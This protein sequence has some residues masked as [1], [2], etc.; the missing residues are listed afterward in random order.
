MKLGVFTPVVA[1]IPLEEALKYLHTK[2]VQMVEIG[3][4]GY[5]GNAHCDPDQLLGHPEKLQQF[6]DLLKKYDLELS[7]LSCHSNPVHPPK[8]GRP[9][10]GSADSQNDLVGRE[11][12]PPQHQHFLWLSW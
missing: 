7:A 5:P 8:E 10:G 12:G 1:N 11:T 3:T 4:G 6:Q 9:G 2:G